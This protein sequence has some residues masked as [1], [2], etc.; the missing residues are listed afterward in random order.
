MNLQKKTKGNPF[1]T[2]H[3]A[4][5]LFALVMLL[6]NTSVWTWTSPSQNSV[7]TDRVSHRSRLFSQKSADNNLFAI[8]HPQQDPFETAVLNR[9][10]C[11][12][13]LRYDGKDTNAT[14]P[15]SSSVATASPAN[16]TVLQKAMHA[17]DLARRTPTAFNTQPFKVVLVHSVEQKQRLSKYC[18]LADKQIMR[19]FGRYREFLSAE[20]ERQ[21]KRPLSHWR[22]LQQLFY[23][24]IFSSGYP[25]PRILRVPISFCVRA[26]MAMLHVCITRKFYPL[27]SLADSETWTSKQ[28]TMVAMTYMLACTHAGL[29]TLPMEGFH[30]GSI[31]RHVIHAPARY[32]IPLLVS[33]GTEYPSRTNGS[34]VATKSGMTARYSL[35]EVVFGDSF[36]GTFPL[37]QPQAG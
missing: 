7:A 28:A 26:L 8:G 32:A 21:N 4:L 14:T 37:L 22:L 20:R 3:D 36:G 35:D 31:R 29:A 10:A 27:P 18:F 13:F 9:H 23:I 5:F 19:D 24:C 12:R 2:F 17:L 30:A 33:V 1:V 16:P 6:Q 34:T 11:K 15:S 25:L